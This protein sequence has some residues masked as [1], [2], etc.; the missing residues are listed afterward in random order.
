MPSV[1]SNSALIIIASEN[2]ICVPSPTMIPKSVVLNSKRSLQC[3]LANCSPSL[4]TLNAT[5]G[6]ARKNKEGEE[7]ISVILTNPENS[8]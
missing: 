7:E 5:D 4:L 8:I 2:V 3:L 1:Y 6:P